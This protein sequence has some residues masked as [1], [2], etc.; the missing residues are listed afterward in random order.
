M[1]VRKIDPPY[2]A[3]GRRTQFL[4]SIQGHWVCFIRERVQRTLPISSHTDFGSLPVLLTLR[5]WAVWNRNQRLSIILLVLY[6]LCW[7]SALIITFWFGNSITSKWNL[8][9]RS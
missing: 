8:D 4:L 9:A 7:G 3:Q 1:Q 6:S 5:T 2:I